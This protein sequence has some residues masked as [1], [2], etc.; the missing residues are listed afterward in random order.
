MS[1]GLARVTIS[2]PQRRV[3]VALPERVPLAELLPDLLRHAGEDLADQGETQGGWVLRRGDGVALATGQ[4]LWTQGVRDGEVLH[5]VAAHDEWPEIEYDDVVEA[6]AEGARRHGGVWTP[7]ATRAA[8]LAAA[9]VPLGLGLF[10]LVAAGPGQGAA[11]LG[12]A[13]V[14]LLG[15]AFADRRYGGPRTGTALGG[16]G[17]PYAFAGGALL[18]AAGPD[19]LAGSVALLVASVVAAAGLRAGSR[20]FAAGGTAGVLGALGAATGEITTPAGAAAVLLSVLVCGLGALPLLAVRFGRTPLPPPAAPSRP[21]APASE[22]ARDRVDRGEVFA[23]VE[24]TQEILLGMLLGHAL[25]AAVAFAVLAA[26][27]TLSARILI[28]AGA[29]ALLTRARLFVTGRLR[30]PLL[31]AGLIGLAALGVDL[32][33]APAGADLPVLPDADLPAFA[34]GALPGLIAVVLL[35]ALVTVLAGVRYAD[36]P[37]SPYLRRAADVLEVVAVISVIPVTCAVT[38]LY[39]AV[40]GLS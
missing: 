15:G 37:P 1:T 19:L 2:A 38:G 26:D 5:L 32:L 12:A 17:L 35:V 14:L 39:T 28:A 18:S 20:V 22:P 33:T 36:R 29:I 23:A 27:R 16:Y 30:A 7:A 31:A 6:V 25:V 11:G 4:D 21:G 3:D 9:G 24:R 10:A 34:G 8:T 40:S 13:A